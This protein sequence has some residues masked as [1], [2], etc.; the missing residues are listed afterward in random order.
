MEDITRVKGAIH[1]V[2]WWLGTYF[3]VKAK[4]KSLAPA[5][6]SCKALGKS[7]NLAEP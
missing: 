1:G 5:V 2:P 3:G 6:K 4:F 7:K